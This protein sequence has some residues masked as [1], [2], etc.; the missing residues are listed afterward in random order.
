MRP[1]GCAAAVHSDS[2]HSSG[3]M[4]NRFM[5]AVLFHNQTAFEADILRR[6]AYKN[7]EFTRMYGEVVLHVVVVAESLFPEFYRYA[8][9][10]TF[11][12][13]DLS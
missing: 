8:T 5:T 2:M 11:L 4:A 6:R 3:N 13:E 12:Q 7:V 10:L 1:E 9:G